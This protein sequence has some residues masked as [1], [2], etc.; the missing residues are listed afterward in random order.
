M[1]N[2]YQT[3]WMRNLKQRSSLLLGFMKVVLFP[4]YLLW[5]LAEMMPQLTLRIEELL[6]FLTTPLRAVVGFLQAWADGRLWHKLWAASP[7]IVMALV[8]FSVF[9]INVNKN[10]GRAYAGYYQGAVKSMMAGDYKEADFLFAKLI[11]HPSYKNNDEVLYRALISAT[12]TGNV[13]RAKAL[14]D[15][16]LRE[17]DYEPAKRWL[18]ENHISQK[19]I[20]ELKGA[21]MLDIATAMLASA[22]TTEATEYWKMSLAR[23][24][25]KLQDYD[26]AITLLKE[27]EELKPKGYLLLAQVLVIKGDKTE[28]IEVLERMLKYI[29]LK[30]PSESIYFN[31]KVEGWALIAANARTSERAVELL[32]KAMELVEGKRALSLGQRKMYSTWLSELNIRMFRFALKNRNESSRRDGFKYFDAAL[33]HG[34][35]PDRAGESIL[36]AV[37]STASYSLLSGQIV[38]VAA[39]D[40][41]CGVHLALGL[42]AWLQNDLDRAELHFRVANAIEENAVEVLRAAA[43]DLGQRSVNAQLDMAVFRGV[44]RSNYQRSLDLLELVI[45]ID[46]KRSVDVSF[47][48]CYIFSLKENWEGVIAEIEPRLADLNGRNLLLAYNWMSGAYRGM[49]NRELAEEYA[50]LLN[51]EARKQREAK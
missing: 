25:V 11:H 51:I 6:R 3:P 5:R 18:V 26:G 29:E 22:E 17:R 47:D 38:G 7:I 32:P 1:N 19:E 50:R 8:G 27:D 10:R 28:Y 43:R 46:S 40:S 12:Q 33:Q 41:G 49:G 24:M 44:N 13:P 35:V 15:K 21:E 37:N 31:E 36:S 23:L 2:P 9:Y 34:T 4:K 16:L 39:R 20:S 14:E 42:E 30:D 48:R 45:K